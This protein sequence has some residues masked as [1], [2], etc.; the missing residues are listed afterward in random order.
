MDELCISLGS[1]GSGVESLGSGDFKEH[2][3]G[4][5]EM[6]VLH[7]FTLLYVFLL[8]SLLA[9]SEKSEAMTVNFSR[10]SYS[11]SSMEFVDYV[12]GTS[13]KVILVKKID[14]FS[15]SKYVYVLYRHSKRGWNEISELR[16]IHEIQGTKFSISRVHQVSKGEGGS[17][18]IVAS[19]EK[20]GFVILKFS[21][22]EDKYTH[23]ESLDL[24]SIFRISD[25]ITDDDSKSILIGFMPD[26]KVVSLRAY[27]GDLKHQYTNTVDTNLSNFMEIADILPDESDIYLL[28]NQYDSPSSIVMGNA[29]KSSL[30]SVP[31]TKGSEGWVAP[32]EKDVALSGPISRRLIN[33]KGDNS[34]AKGK[35]EVRGE[36]KNGKFDNY[37]INLDLLVGEDFTIDGSSVEVSPS[38]GAVYISSDIVHTKLYLFYFDK[39]IVEK[40]ELIPSI[41]SV[42]NRHRIINERRYFEG[43]KTFQFITFS[44]TDDSWVDRS[45]IEVIEFEES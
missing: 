40:R 42:T 10:L 15:P 23:I 37:I 21:K 16:N 4:G 26:K 38:V 44:Y 28:V 35:P 6:I 31:I 13:G 41:K 29:S 34:E 27:D 7:T 8:C 45:Y 3:S 20:Q 36:I 32:L 22:T 2:S 1:F 18:V 30:V 9:V 19:M 39:N 33:V 17:F 12:S 14:V 43:K 11:D 24:P 5:V 25:F